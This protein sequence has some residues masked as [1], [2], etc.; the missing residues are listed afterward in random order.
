MGYKGAE[1]WSDAARVFPGGPRVRRAGTRQFCGLG[2]DLLVEAE[3]LFDRGD[4]DFKLQ[5]LVYFVLLEL[6]QLGVDAIYLP[7]QVGLYAGEPGVQLIDAAVE[8]GFE[9]GEIILRRHVLDDV[10]DHFAEFFERRFLRGHM[11]GSI[12]RWALH[13][14]AEVWLGPVR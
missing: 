9:L 11:G 8:A 3:V 12:P 7:G 2:R 5:A 14:R 13:C 1:G 6:G 10:G 4:A